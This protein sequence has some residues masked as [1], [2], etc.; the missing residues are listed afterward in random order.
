MLTEVTVEVAIVVAEVGPLEL[1]HRELRGEAE[2]TLSDV[3]LRHEA[4]EALA[5]DDEHDLVSSVDPIRVAALAVT[6]GDRRSLDGLGDVQGR[7]AGERRSDDRI[8]GGSG[9]D[10]AD[11]LL[12][13]TEGEP[14]VAHELVTRD[15]VVTD[16]EG[17]GG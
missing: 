12:V 9:R 13:D 4:L 6:V 10:G 5:G 15:A 2:G 1:T 11:R 8:A 14:A 7:D 16:L 17:S 3:L